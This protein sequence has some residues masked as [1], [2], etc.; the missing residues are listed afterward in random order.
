M[1]GQRMETQSTLQLL[2]SHLSKETVVLAIPSPTL[3]WLSIDW[4]SIIKSTWNFQYKIFLIVILWIKVVT[5]VMVSC[6]TFKWFKPTSFQ[7]SAFLT[8]L[9]TD[10]AKNSLT[11]KWTVRS[12]YKNSDTSEDVMDAPMNTILWRKSTTT[13]QLFYLSHQANNFQCTQAVCILTSLT[14]QAN[15]SNLKDGKKLNTPYFATVGVS[16]T[17]SNTGTVWT[18][19]ELLLVSLFIYILRR[20]W[21]LQ[22]RKRKRLLRNRVNG[23][24]LKP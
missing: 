8:P 4:K 10:H 3:W 24:I 19:G 1:V 7:L 21:I 18:V 11:A 22:N 23:R 17:E 2:E 12:Q 6:K 9:P 16:K 5:E 20:Q 15:K 13:V 14:I